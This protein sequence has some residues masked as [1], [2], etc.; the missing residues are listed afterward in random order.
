MSEYKRS[1]VIKVAAAGVIGTTIEWYDFFVAGTAAA[2]AWPKVFFP[3]SNPTTSLLEA[4]IAFG[5]GFIGRPVGAILFGHFGDRLGR[6]TTL[7]W[8]LLTMGLGTLGIALLPPYASIGVLAGI[9]VVIFRII[10]SLGVGGEWGGATS[11]VSEF[12]TKSK[13]RAF[14]GSWVQQGV[15]FGLIAANVIYLILVSQLSSQDFLNLGWRIP[16]YVG[17]VIIIIGVIIRY[18]IA[19]TP[20]FKAVLERRQVVKVP[21]SSLIKNQGKTVALLAIGW[22]Y[23]NA[24][25]YI[26]AS[27]ALGYLTTYIKVSSSLASLSV[28]LAAVGSIVAI[29]VGSIAAD[30]IGRKKVIIISAVLTAAF[31]AAPYFVLLNTGNPLLIILS[32]VTALFFNQFGYSVLPTYYSEHYPTKYR[33]T[34]TA[35]TY[36]IAAPFSGGLAP[37]LAEYIITAA[38]GNALASWPYIGIM[39]AIYSIAGAIAIGLTRETLREGIN[40]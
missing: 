16:F 15:P 34:G 11:L 7:I 24:T 25:F 14:W 36:H 17:A 12:T 37:I 21:F 19:E 31:F 13:Y 39:A 32:Q 3:S 38:G 18:K 29:V 22:A 33:Y 6:K 9:L 8:T 27:F 23:Q 35:F 2:L 30:Y 28:L 1:E 4:I 26:I 5:V 20:L 10:Q 40:E